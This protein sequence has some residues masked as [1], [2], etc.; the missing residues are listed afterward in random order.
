MSLTPD[1]RM[2]MLLEQTEPHQPN[3]ILAADRSWESFHADLDYAYKNAY[4]PESHRPHNESSGITELDRGILLCYIFWQAILSVTTRRRLLAAV[5]TSA[6]M[7]SNCFLLNVH[8]IGI[9]QIIHVRIT[10]WFWLGQG[11]LPWLK[12]YRQNFS[13]SASWNYSNSI[14]RQNTLLQSSSYNYLFFCILENTLIARHQYSG[15]MPWLSWRSL[16]YRFCCSGSLSSHPDPSQRYL[17]FSTNS[18]LGSPSEIS[19]E[20]PSSIRAHAALHT[21]MYGYFKAGYYPMSLSPCQPVTKDSKLRLIRDA[22]RTSSRQAV[23]CS[24]CCS[25]AALSECKRRQASER[26]YL[27]QFLIEYVWFVCPLN[28][29]KGQAMV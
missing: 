28:S 4:G 26:R 18:S 22:Q 19:R 27:L 23:P 7:L 6:L 21:P 17:P 15:K 9:F 14:L 2:D 1:E 5:V 8:Q 24:Q 10:Q 29:G 13:P 3:S 25:S 20:G 12:Q 11:R 16:K